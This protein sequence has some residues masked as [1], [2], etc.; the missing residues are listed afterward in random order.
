MTAYSAQTPQLFA[1]TATYYSR[2][3]PP[4]RDSMFT[5]LRE[6]FQLDG[7]GRLLDLG[8]GPGALTIPLA[9]MFAEVVAMDPSDEM[10]AEGERVAAARALANIEWRGGSSED[11]S[12]APGPFRLVTMGNSFHWM[13]REK[14][15]DALYPLVEDGGGVAIVAYGFPFPEDAPIEPWRNK[16]AEIVLKYAAPSHFR[17]YGIPVPVESR[18]ESSVQRS[19]FKLARSWKERYEQTWTIDEMIGNLYSTSYCSPRLLGSNREAFERELR[20]AMREFSITGILTEP[21]E[22]WAVLAFK[23]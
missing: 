18:F 15:L 4:Y 21:Q 19:Q 7:R 5:L 11:L 22:I 14:T 20:A 16:V 2:F 12:A 23:P 17:G 9:P 13:N 3:R 6:T 10:R 8:C 1:G